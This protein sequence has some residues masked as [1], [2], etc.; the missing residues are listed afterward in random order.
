MHRLRIRAGVAGGAAI[1]LLAALA[2]CG[3]GD[4]EKARLAFE[5]PGDST[6]LPAGHPPVGASAAAQPGAGTADAV[7]GLE[8]QPPAGWTRGE[9]RPMRVATYLVGAAPGDSEG[10]ECAVYY[11]GSGQ[12]GDVGANVQRWIGQFDQPDGRSSSDVALTDET[13]VNG[14]RVTT[15]ELSGTYTGMMSPM[16][17]AKVEKRGFQMLGAIVE[18]P[19]GAVFFKLTGPEQ[20]VQEARSGFDGLIGSVRRSP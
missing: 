19:E 10:G 4:A 14:L 17:G 12:G 20:T 18:G 8:W 9:D 5:E 15:V 7:A 3:G 13:S 2:G 16:S 11:F 1:L 6:R